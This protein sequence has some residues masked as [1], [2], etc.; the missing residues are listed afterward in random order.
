[1]NVY[2]VHAGN[3]TTIFIRA[4]NYTIGQRELLTFWEE[5]GTKQLATFAS[6]HYVI[7][8]G[9]EVVVS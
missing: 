2:K 8:V 6:W 1:M 3:G 9:S 4:E 5:D 7:L